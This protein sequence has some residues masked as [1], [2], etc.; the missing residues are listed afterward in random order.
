MGYNRPSPLRSDNPAHGR[1]LGSQKPQPLLLWGTGSSPR[2]VLPTPLLDKV[3]ELKLPLS[4]HQ[5]FWESL[6]SVWLPTCDCSAY[7]EQ[8]SIPCSF[9]TAN[10]FPS[11]QPAWPPF[12]RLSPVLCLVWRAFSMLHAWLAHSL[13]S[14]VS[15]LKCYFMTKDI[16]LHTVLE[17][18]IL[19]L[20]FWNI[21]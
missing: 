1:K 13:M 11:Y 18:P 14:F 17:L 10:L 20:F 4:F 8:P 3:T 5:G 19:G 16:F 6:A 2:L 9:S 15:H 12:T 7:S 21:I